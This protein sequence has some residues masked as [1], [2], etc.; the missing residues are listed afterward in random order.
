[1]G[2]GK[3]RKFAEMET[4]PNVVQETMSSMAELLPT[5]QLERDGAAPLL[6]PSKMQ[7]KWGA[8]FDSLQ[9]TILDEDSSGHKNKAENHTPIVLELGCGRGEYTVGWRKCFLRKDSLE[10]ISKGQE[11]GMEHARL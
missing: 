4:F 7:G 3:L 1:M 9:K 5:L 6:P 2:H 10:L 11:C 8:F